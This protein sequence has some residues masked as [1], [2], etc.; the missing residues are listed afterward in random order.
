M[1]QLDWVGEPQA[2]P[3]KDIRNTRGS[4]AE[5]KARICLLLGARINTIPAMVRDGTIDQTR[6][7]KRDREAAAKVCANKRSSV[8]D[9]ESA[10][11]S[12][13]KWV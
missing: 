10:L 9:L 12:M 1:S 8:G 13:A 4:V 3:F 11:N 2:Q 7:W 5:E 6:A